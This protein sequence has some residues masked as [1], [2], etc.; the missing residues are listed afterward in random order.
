MLGGGAGLQMQ[1]QLAE[2]DDM[3]VIAAQRSSEIAQ[4]ASSV[5]ELNRI[6]KDLA[7]LV[8]D[9]GT[10]LD[11][12]DFNTEKIYQRSDEAKGQLH[13]AV[14]RKKESDS[15]AWKCLLVWGAADLILL[16]VLLVKYQL[17]YGLKNVALFLVAIAL[18]LAVCYFGLKQYKPKVIAE[19]PAYFEKILPEGPGGSAEM[20]ALGWALL[21]EA[22]SA[23]IF[24]ERSDL[25]AA[26]IEDMRYMF[27]NAR[28]FNQDIGNWNTSQV[29]D[30]RGMFENA[31]SFNQPLRDWDTSSVTE[32]S[33]MFKEAYAFNQAIGDWKILK[34][35]STRR[36]FDHAWHF[37]QPIGLW[38]TSAVE[39]MSYMFSHAH[40]FSQPINSW[41]S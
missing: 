27:S 14:K 23:R 10:V 4:I 18:V 1:Q 12:I 26:V 36:M 37:N 3:E 21:A 34:V 25:R 24:Y 22:C 7:T 20:R 16:I 41:E 38:N 40:H 9:Q 31:H 28:S 35:R 32:M 19:G 29:T 5:A 15:R 6:F 17:K 39:D 33:E 13:Q 11:R 2:L 8:I 30:M